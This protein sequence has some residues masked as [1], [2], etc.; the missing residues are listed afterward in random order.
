ML[1]FGK[2]RLLDLSIYVLPTL[3][4]IGLV[5]GYPLIRVI[6]LSFVRENAFVG[7]ENYTALFDDRVFATAL[8]NNA[9]LLLAVPV[10]TVLAVPIAMLLHERPRGWQIYRTLI[11]MPYILAIPVSAIAIGAIVSYRGG[12]NQFLNLVG[13]DALVVDWLG[14][15]STALLVVIAAMIWRELGFGVVLF[16]A[17]LANVDE[18]LF[19]AAQIDGANWWQQLRFITI[20]GIR[21]VIVFYVVIE[22]IT[23]LVWTFAWVY[24]LTRGGPAGSTM[25]LDLYIFQQ[26]I[27]FRSYGIGAAAAVVLLLAVAGLVA[28]SLLTGRKVDEYG[29]ST[30]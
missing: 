4:V 11:F 12:L 10:M 1:G 3:L 21:G 8:K 14:K 22:L 26:T 2:T 15:P 30:G 7:L 24:V 20:P 19:E 23:V 28:I 6:Q 18:T 17:A 29:S 9:S 16:M 27:Q 25:V 5:F 13:L